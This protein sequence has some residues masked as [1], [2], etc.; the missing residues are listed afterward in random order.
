MNSVMLEN[1]VMAIYQA[2]GSER[3]IKP[4]GILSVPCESYSE[5][6][7]ICE[8]TVRNNWKRYQEWGHKKY[9]TYLAFLASR[10]APIGV[11]NDPTNL[12]KNWLKNVQHF[13]Y[14]EVA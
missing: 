1:I 2:E 12:N 14:K 4:F 13:L 8:N 6:K 7:K 11:S 9:P 5:C 3:A 10:Y